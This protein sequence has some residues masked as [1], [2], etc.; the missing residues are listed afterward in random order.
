MKRKETLI[1]DFSHDFCDFINP[2]DV[3]VKNEFFQAEEVGKPSTDGEC[4]PSNLELIAAVCRQISSI[5]ERINEIGVFVGVPQIIPFNGNFTLFPARVGNVQKASPNYVSYTINLKPHRE[6]FSYVRFKSASGLFE[7]ED[8]VRGLI[9]DDNGEVECYSNNKLG[10]LGSD[11]RLPITKKSKLLI[12]TVPAE[13]GE[14][15]IIPTEI[16]FLPHGLLQ[17]FSKSIRSINS[18]INTLFN[19]VIPLEREI[20]NLSKKQVNSSASE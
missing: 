11:T 15:L 20:K 6:L 19:D 3:A 13:Q 8:I 4:E 18:D 7:E 1:D 9:V 2:N 14:P 5:N 12:V 16:V 17:E 10:V